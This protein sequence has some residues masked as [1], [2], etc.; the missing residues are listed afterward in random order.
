MNLSPIVLFVYNR[1]WHTQQTIE[2][3]QKNELAL[4]SELFIYADNAKNDE[5]LSKVKEVRNYL[6]TVDGFKNITIIERD[7]NWGLANSII[8][9]VTTTVNKYGKVIVLED[10]LVTSPYFLRYMNEA[11]TLYQNE[12][13]V[14]SIHGYIYPLK[15]TNNLPETFFIKGA[16]CW[17][18]ATWQRAWD[19]F[20]ADGKKLLKELQ[21]RKLQNEIDFNGSYGFTE[22]LE[23]QIKGKNNSWAIRWYISAFLQNKLTL[24]PKK[25]LVQNIGMDDSGTH[26]GSSKEYYIKNLNFNIPVLSNQIIEN[27][28]ARNEI[29][30]FFFTPARN[31]VEGFFLQPINFLKKIIKNLFKK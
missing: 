10:D 25:S 16:D 26:C 24:Y 12:Q 2:A 20:E 23:K 5:S 22:M 4:E 3:L 15:N 30:K 11:L 8:D 21:V 27:K 18:W 17:G 31:E 28:C 14:A 19:L 1:L 9:G 6:K 7:K 13:D 29:E